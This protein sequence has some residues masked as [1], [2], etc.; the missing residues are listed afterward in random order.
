LGLR[1]RPEAR[2]DIREA[3]AWYEEKAS[4]LG[5]EFARAVD[6]AAT[7]ILRFPKAFPT[8]HGQVRKAVL[9]RFPYSL[10]FIVESDDIVVLG[11][12]HHRRDPRTWAAPS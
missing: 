7:G 4:G 8:V 9:R 6:G 2:L 10:L 5:S 11:C 1:F 3:R 12:F